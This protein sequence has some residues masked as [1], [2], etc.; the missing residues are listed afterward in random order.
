MRLLPLAWITGWMFLAGRSDL[1]GAPLVWQT[2]QGCR[3]ASLAVASEG[4]PGFTELNTEQTGIS[5]TNWLPAERYLTHQ[6]LLNGSGVAAGDVDG[7]GYCDLFFCG[8]DR[9]SAL[10][11]NLGNWRF[12][13]ITAESGVACS[14]Q[15]STGAVFADVDGDGHLDLLVNGLGTGTRLFLNDGHGHFHEATDEWGLRSGTGSMSMALGDVDGDGFLD[16]YVANYRSTTVRDELQVRL[17]TAVT[18]NQYTVLA[19][20][21]RPVSEPDLQGRFV[22]DPAMGLLENGQADAFYRNS[23]HGRFVKTSWTDGTFLDEDGRPS[24]V[25]Y[26]WGLSVM[27]RDLNGDGAP[28]IYV[29]NDFHSPDRIWLNDGHGRYRA[30]PRLA[31]RQT[32]LFS[33]GVDFADLDRDGRD[34]FFVA[35]MLSRQHARRQVQL[36]DRRALPLPLGAIENRPQYSRNTLFWNRGDGTYAEIA[37]YSGLEASEWTWCPV[38]LDVDLDGYED[39]LLVTGHLRD[40][41]NIDIARRIERMKREKG[42][43]RL[44]QLSLRRLFEPLKVPNLAF[45]NRGDLTFEEMGRA[46]GFDS[47]NVS[48]GIALADLDNDGDLDVIVNCLN[49]RPLLLR[50]NT[51]RPRV[52]VR[53]RG[54]PPN[55]RGIGSRII[56]SQP[57]LCQQS[58]EIICG[59]RYLSGDE[60]QRVFAAANVDSDLTIDVRWRSGHRSLIAHARPNRVY[61]IDEAQADGPRPP[62]PEAIAPMFA[63]VSELIHHRHLG[64]GFDD[65]QRQPL[66]PHSLSQ[67]GPGVAWFDVDGDGWEDLMI[68]SGQGGRLGLFKNNGHGGFVAWDKPPFDAKAPQDE[69]AVVGWREGASAARLLVGLT[70][71]EDA[72]TNGAAAL[73]YDLMPT[74]SPDAIRAPGV[75]TGPVAVADLDGKGTLGVFVGGRV[76]P[77]QFPAP[78]GSAILVT[79]NGKLQVDPVMSAELTRVGMVSGAIWSDLN[80]D[81]VPELVLACEAGP[82]RIFELGHGR[83]R[84]RTD[85]LGLGKYVGLWNSVAVGDFDGD[86]RM[87][88]VAGNWG[89]NTK[90]ESY[91]ARPI[92]WYYGDVDG[93]G[94]T[95]VIDAYSAPELGKIVPWRDWET[96]SRAMP[97]LLEHYHSFTQFST[98]SVQEFMGQRLAQL[99]DLQFNTL[100]SMLFLNRGDHFEAHPLPPEAQFA[101][102]FGLAVGDVDG[103]GKEDVVISQNFFEVPPGDSRL[104]GGRGLWLRGDGHGALESV[105]GQKSGLAIYGEGRGLALCDYDH[106]GRVDMVAAQNGNATKLYHNLGGKPGLRVVLEGDARNPLGIGAQMQVEFADGTTGPAREVHAGG[107]YWSQ[108]S[109]TQVL[110]LSGVPKAL[111]VRWPGERNTRTAVAPGE[112]EIRIKSP[113]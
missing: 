80:G 27:F 83:L 24:A 113:R 64:H 19:V 99:K 46:W 2:A 79:Q 16:L 36:M 58:Q 60:A 9:R 29:C 96:L 47:R 69:A 67:L 17:K 93:A 6:I 107:G 14:G 102:V 44:E 52:A 85:A 100:K 108:D 12:V 72:Q 45:R 103:D 31:L 89:Q 4:K 33:M 11:R 78:A 62:L 15:S 49:D 106:D 1:A 25:P 84:E 40:A 22:V 13:D 21:G 98:A 111:V 53:L 104:D 38:F 70:H 105:P 34:D 75:N 71:Y 55:T 92:H 76:I 77:G 87:D 86:G 88:I 5:F 8:I 28:D 65:Y 90:Y 109:A 63:D 37:R 81:G 91:L 30:I 51:N 101:P 73:L 23:G 26:D 18:N 32:S 94:M 50:N 95:T 41:Q 74:N 7:D 57:G 59:G 61:E 35:D 110:G 112:R 43:S 66:L 42:R 20:N 3:W 68:T 39:L 10:Y 56:V 82:V 97:F 48:Q 54:L